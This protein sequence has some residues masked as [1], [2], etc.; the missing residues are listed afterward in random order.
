MR[1]QRDKLQL[2]SLAPP[3]RQ[4]EG[5][6]ITEAPKRPQIETNKHWKLDMRSKRRTRKIKAKIEKIE[7]QKQSSE[8]IVAGLEKQLLAM[9]AEVKKQQPQSEQRNVTWL[10]PTL[11]APTSWNPQPVIQQHNPTC[12][13]INQ[14]TEAELK[15]MVL[16]GE[17]E[18]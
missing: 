14:V 16:Q 2:F 1:Q 15:R 9:E 12:E 8:N 5:R 13:L 17:I 3:I 4:V 11:P 18:T 10:K 6:A 7:S